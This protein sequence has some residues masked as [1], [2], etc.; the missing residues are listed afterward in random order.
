MKYK[1]AHDAKW[2]YRLVEAYSRPLLTCLNDAKGKVCGENCKAYVELYNGR[3]TIHK[4][5]GWN[6]LD[7]SPDFA[8]AME[9][10]LV[11][12]ALYQWIDK[13][14]T[15]ERFRRCADQQFYCITKNSCGHQLSSVMY[16][17]IRGYQNAWLV[18]GAL[19]AIWGLFSRPRV[20]CETSLSLLN[21]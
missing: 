10:S 8:C 15:R 4:N 21:P 3:I 13:C 12:D 6:G 2:P 19:G 11:H 20:S 18:G 17:A 1:C 16:N 9:A 5:Y 7:W 14:E